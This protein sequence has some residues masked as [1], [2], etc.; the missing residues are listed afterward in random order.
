MATLVPEP[1]TSRATDGEKRVYALL[2]DGLPAHFFGW[3][4]P[5]VQGR[6][7]DFL[8]MASDFGLLV[9]EVKGWYAGQIARADSHE[10]ELHRRVSGQVQIERHQHPERQ[11]RDYLLTLLDV[12]SRPEYAILRN[13]AGRHQ[14][15]PCFPWGY[16]VVLTNIT[17][18]QLKEAELAGM[19]SPERTM[20]RD[21]LQ[22]LESLG[23]AGLV[24]RLK[25]C[26]RVWFP[27][28]PLTEDQVATLKGVIHPEI[29]VKRRPATAESAEQG[30][31]LLPGAIALEVLDAEQ[32]KVARA[33]GEGHHVVFGVAGSGKTVLL[34]ARARMLAERHPGGRLL[35]LCFN[36]AL[37]A[38][39][40]SALGCDPNLRRVE[41][42]HFDSW[43]ASRVRV[44]KGDEDW[45][46]YRGKLIQGLLRTAES[47]SD[48]DRYD[49][50]LID[51]AHDF[52]PDWF[53]CAV[54][55]LRGGDDGELLIA[56]DGAQSLYPRDR[57][58]TWKSVG[59]KAVGRTRRLARNY[60]NTKIILEFA[61]Q[62]GQSLLP[63]SEATETHVRVVPTRAARQGPTPRYHGCATVGEE[64]ALIASLVA[65]FRTKGIPDREI[66]VLY[67]RNER[68][69]ANAPGRAD[70]LRQVLAA[71]GDVCCLSAA[72][73]VRALRT[74]LAGP[75][76]RLATIHAAK[77]L[78][79]R[80]VIL[81]ALDLL[82]S[83]WEP[84]EIRDS[85]LLYVGLTRA[86][87]ELVV[88]WTGRSAFTE[89]VLRS[90]KALPLN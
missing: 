66:A 28:H 7:P 43:L 31:G 76:V 63:E 51:E 64:H 29:V 47:W 60:R 3:F 87:D 50:I 32:E 15:K 46:V 67:P 35:V 83:P 88:T 56:L 82:P 9:L 77:G 68:M 52:A 71:E 12:V 4:E 81:A 10:V 24:E 8:V 40:A 86:L 90:N 25:G 85:K 79:F 84:D 61:W 62:V 44:A 5:V 19:F 11:A 78:E 22:G 30:Q 2:R 23:G 20:C 17:R 59:V 57:T 42:R 36:K 53:R 33:M 18:A 74:A 69:R 70:H 27:F 65:D 37:A 89:R 38:Y 39:L 48:A 75:G 34:L 49:A 21:E 6:Y 58:F 55:A 54:A 1:C 13:P 16:G 45:E 26:F 80:A 72:E 41:V 14:G 73:D